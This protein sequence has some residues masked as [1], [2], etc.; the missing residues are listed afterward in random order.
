MTP[1]VRI[2]ANV[3]IGAGS[4]VIEDI[5]DNVRAAGAPARPLRGA[6]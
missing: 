2:G 5:A 4:T 3:V 6:A 1:G